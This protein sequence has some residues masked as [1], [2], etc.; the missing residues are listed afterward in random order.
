MT[1]CVF[2]RCASVGPYDPNM[3]S[4]LWRTNDQY[5]SLSVSTTESTLVDVRSI[6]SATNQTATSP[7]FSRRNSQASTLRRL[8]HTDGPHYV[9]ETDYRVEK[10]AEKSVT[11][12]V[13]SK[14]DLDVETLVS[15]RGTPEPVRGYTRL[16]SS[17]RAWSPLWLKQATPLAFCAVFIALVAALIVLWRVETARHGITLTVAHNEHSWKYGPTASKCNQLV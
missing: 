8:S 4:S 10:K 9:V 1:D 6:E 11:V 13:Q 7:T 3:K 5:D 2:T 15:T 14:E 16:S 17:A 12:A